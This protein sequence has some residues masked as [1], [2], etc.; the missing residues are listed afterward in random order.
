MSQRGLLSPSAGTCASARSPGPS[1]PQG[2]PSSSPQDARRPPPGPLAGPSQC[3]CCGLGV[4]L[5]LFLPVA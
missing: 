4:F 1:C 2:L 3:C 5:F